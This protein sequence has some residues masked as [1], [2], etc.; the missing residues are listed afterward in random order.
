MNMTET[1]N[2]EFL[3]PEQRITKL[4]KQVKELKKMIEPSV[5]DVELPKSSVRKAEFRATTSDIERPL[6]PENRIIKEGA[7]PTR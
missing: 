3:T 2:L 4:E 1:N 6:A 7:R 5:L